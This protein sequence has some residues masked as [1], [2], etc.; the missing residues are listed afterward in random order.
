MNVF[1][2][3]TIFCFHFTCL[4]FCS[5]MISPVSARFS[6]FTLGDSAP[7]IVICILPW[8]YLKILPQPLACLQWSCTR[9]L[10]VSVTHVSQQVTAPTW[11]SH[12][13]CN[14]RI[15]CTNVEGPKTAT[16]GFPLEG[17]RWRRQFWTLIRRDQ[18]RQALLSSLLWEKSYN[19]QAP[20]QRLGWQDF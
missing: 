7:C 1:I 6:A 14:P 13:W 17:R 8:W 20:R 15:I 16:V 19:M 2:F 4:A 10:H 3:R 12:A 5:Y 18:T 9:S 11:F